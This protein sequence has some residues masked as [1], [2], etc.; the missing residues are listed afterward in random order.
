M[1]EKT[2]FDAASFV[3]IDLTQGAISSAAQDRLALVPTQILRALEP[4]DALDEAALE[5]GK[6]HGRLLAEQ[7]DIDTET[8]SLELLASHL[9]GTLAAFG[10]GRMSLEIQGA[11]LM[12]RTAGRDGAP[13]AKGVC[14]LLE[15]F[16]AGYLSALGERLFSVVY[17]GL[18]GEDGLFWAGNP[19]LSD[20]VRRLAGQ[21]MAPSRVIGTLMERGV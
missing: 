5:W 12:F 8:T 15:G 1:M 7:I 16:L 6:T 4:G 18:D 17:L 9:G 10:M 14:A 20:E 2:V 19:A 3:E 21:G 11:A 13:P